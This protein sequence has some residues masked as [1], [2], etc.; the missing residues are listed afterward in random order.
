M[1]HTIGLLSKVVLLGLTILLFWWLAMSSPTTSPE[2]A[3][4]AGS[5][6]PAP[7]EVAASPARVPPKIAHRPTNSEVNNPQRT[8]AEE[9]SARVPK[10][11]GPV[12]ELSQRY[13]SE[14]RAQTSAEDEAQVRAA[15][16]DPAIPPTLLRSVECR[17]SVCRVELRWRPEHQAGYILGLTRAVSKY[18]VPVGIKGAGPSEADGHHPVVVYIGLA[19]PV[20]S[21]F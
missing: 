2:V 5:S 10:R 12:A 19:R 21:S 9:A 11:Q 1:H 15:Y 16:V 20:P 4:A 17:R 13:A 8:A 14:S 6:A 7:S 18:V 3:A